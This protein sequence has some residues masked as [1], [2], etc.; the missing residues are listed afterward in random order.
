MQQEN[1][2]K[3]EE[4]VQL[5][6]ENTIHEINKSYETP[7]FHIKFKEEAFQLFEYLIEHPYKEDNCF[8]P[9]ITKKDIETLK[10]LSNFNSEL[11]IVVVNDHILFF[12]YLTDIINSLVIIYKK[13]NISSSARALAIRLLRRIWLRM[14]PTDIEQIELFLQRQLAFLSLNS[15]DYYQQETFLKKYYDY[16][17]KIKTTMNSTW[18]E[19]TRCMHFKIY[20]KENNYHSLSNIYYD[21]EKEDNQEICYIYA[22]QSERELYPKRV[23]KIERFLYKI[24]KDVILEETEEYLE[25][26]KQHNTYY[27]ENISDVH[28]NQVHALLF[29]IEVLKLNQI[30]KIK[31]PILQILSYEYHVKLS[32]D[33]KE[34]FKNKYSHS[35][36]N[37]LKEEYLWDKQWYE[38]IV[39]KEDFISK[40]KIETFIRVFRR[41][42]FHNP[43]IIIR[44]VPMLEGD[45]LDIRLNQSKTKTLE[46]I[47]ND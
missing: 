30:T 24:N 35:N 9:S 33:T 18:D 31:A 40:N 42:Q 16:D 47:K 21:I 39:E 20:D 3:F 44:N 25:Y 43:E 4:V 22:I 12:N 11:S 29:F 6:V 34:Q 8:I 13:Y 10:Q 23:P 19:A 15:L 37:H 26:K 45:Y 41:A 28:P 46:K 27:P 32:E 7:K 17:V 5:F 38:H 36:A 2:V 14:G 1:K